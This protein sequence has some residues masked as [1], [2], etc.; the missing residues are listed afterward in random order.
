VKVDA[1]QYYAYKPDT[2]EKFHVS[3]LC[4]VA[5]VSNVPSPPAATDLASSAICSYGSEVRLHVLPEV[6]KAIKAYYSANPRFIWSEGEQINANAR[7]AIAALMKSDRFGLSPSDYSVALPADQQREGEEWIKALVR[8]EFG[9]SAA[10]LT[11][12]LDATRGRIDP[13]R[14]SGYHDIPRKNVDLLPILHDIAE[15]EQAD[16][17]L[18]KL[19]PNNRQFQALTA[20]LA[21]Q[22]TAMLKQVQVPTSLFV[23]PGEADPALPR[24]IAAIR[25]VGADNLKRDHKDALAQYADQEEYVAPLVALVRDFQ[26]EHG[27]HPDGIIGPK[28]LRA[29]ND[30]GPKAKVKKL[31]LALERLRWLPVELGS[32]HVF[33]NQPAFRVAYYAGGR[34]TVAMRAIIGKA[35]NQTYFFAD[36][37]EAVEYNPY[38]NVPRSIIVNEMIPKLYRDPSY[39]DRLGYEVI[40]SSGRK[41]SSS[42]VDWS[43]VAENK[44]SINVRQAP[45]KQNALGQ[46]KIEFPNKHAIYMH[47]TP[48]KELFKQP[49]RTFSHGCVR[50]ERPRILAAALLKT[51]PDHIDSRI[52]DGANDSEPVGE[53]PVYIAYFTAWPNER[54]KVEY[55]ADVYDRDAHLASA[56]VRTE[57]AR[58]ASHREASQ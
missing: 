29:V 42:S 45:G 25:S 4:A 41:V 11:Y 57:A 7:E 26:R 56:V 55:Y 32:R 38:W 9:L 36:K 16:A 58:A 17:Y 21:S 20:E 8:F 37:I 18:E 34:E 27:L 30:A 44:R 12:A 31:E 53:I 24:F 5:T 52:A 1:P 3:E 39:L 28:T 13:N 50:L 19:H 22:R 14:I 43:A 51:T 2:L 49:V 46:L 48:D 6:A 15:T 33:L 47:D 23:R 10:V 35:S 54:G 40:A